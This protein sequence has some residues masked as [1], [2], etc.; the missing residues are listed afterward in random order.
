MRILFVEESHVINQPVM[1][2]RPL[3]RNV[4]SETHVFLTMVDPTK[5]MHSWKSNRL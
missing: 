2:F 5:R 3:S 4:T 1:E